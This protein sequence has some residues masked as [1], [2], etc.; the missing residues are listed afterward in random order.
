M[1]I[2]CNRICIYRIA[3]Y[4]IKENNARREEK[5]SNNLQTK[6]KLQIVFFNLIKF[7]NTRIVFRNSIAIFLLLFLIRFFSV[8]FKWLNVYVLFA[9]QLNLPIDIQC[10]YFE[11]AANK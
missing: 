10:F 1:F 2:T 8:S 11:K 7:V 5:F 6:C 4:Y 9:I 3:I